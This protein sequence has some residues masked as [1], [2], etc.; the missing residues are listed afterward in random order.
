MYKNDHENIIKSNNRVFYVN[1]FVKLILLA[2]VLW[3]GEPCLIEVIIDLIKSTSNW[4]N[5]LAGGIVP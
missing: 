5:S 1:L 2:F 3:W 4:I